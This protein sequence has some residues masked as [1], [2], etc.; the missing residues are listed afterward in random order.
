MDR[1]DDEG[2]GY[3]HQH[4]RRQ[5]DIRINGLANSALLKLI[6][7]SLTLVMLPV[8]GWMAV[9]TIGYMRSIEHELQR[10]SSVSELEDQRIRSLE[11]TKTLRDAQVQRIIDANTS[12]EI[13]IHDLQTRL[14]MMQ[15]GSHQ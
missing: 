7:N 2:S 5:T 3:N 15:Q 10:I 9:Q 1:M 11:G 4:T 6:M 8:L 14:T 12:Q 13:A